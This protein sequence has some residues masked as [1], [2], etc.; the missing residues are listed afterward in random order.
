MSIALHHRALVGSQHCLTLSF[1]VRR[2]IIYQYTKPAGRAEYIE[3][4]SPYEYISPYSP[5]GWLVSLAQGWREEVGIPYLEFQPDM[6]VGAHFELGERLYEA[7]YILIGRLHIR[8]GGEARVPY[9]GIVTAKHS[10]LLNSLSSSFMAIC[11]L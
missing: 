1:S 11:A 5:L 9:S 3:R 2:F 7:C 8:V 4:Q 6:L 10:P